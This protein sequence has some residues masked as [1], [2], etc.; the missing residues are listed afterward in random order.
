MTIYNNEKEKL[1]KLRSQ[2]RKSFFNSFHFR[3]LYVICF[4]QEVKIKADE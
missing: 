1:N 4:S 2:L 3:S